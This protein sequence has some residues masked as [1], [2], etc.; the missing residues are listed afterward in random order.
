MKFAVT[1]LQEKYSAFR[2]CLV[3]GLCWGCWYL[4]MLILG[5]GVPDGIPWPVFLLSMF[6]LTVV[7]GWVY[8]ETRSGLVLLVMQIVSNCAFFIVPVLPAWWGGD[9]TYVVAFVIA[10]TVIALLVVWRAGPENL[11]SRVRATWSGR[12][13]TGRTFPEKRTMLRRAA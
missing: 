11:S 9:P 12:S 8:N 13:P 1:R 5:E 4:P 10:F 7:L 3:V 2:S 6:S